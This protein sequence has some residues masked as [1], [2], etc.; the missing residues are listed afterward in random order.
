MKKPNK[1]HTYAQLL[2]SA[3]W[4]KHYKKDGHPWKPER[5]TI[6]L[7]T[8]IDNMVTGLTRKDEPQKP[9]GS[10]TFQPITIAV[11]VNTLRNIKDALATGEEFARDALTEHDAALGRS[12]QKNR[13]W[14]EAIETDIGHL[15]GLK[16]VL[17]KLIGDQVSD[18]KGMGN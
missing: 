12:T 3:I 4:T 17:E 16:V 10:Q 5:T 9:L 2:T 8:Q 13:R 1:L 11:D 6:G 18:E 7:L 14:A 15:A